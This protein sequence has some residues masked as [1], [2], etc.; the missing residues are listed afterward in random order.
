VLVGTDVS[1]ADEI[2]AE[3]ERRKKRAVALHLPQTI[4]EFFLYKVRNY[5]VWRADPERTEY[6][7]QVVNDLEQQI[8]ETSDVKVYLFSHGGT[9]YRFSWTQKGRDSYFE[10]HSRY[11][12]IAWTGNLTLYVDD[13]QVF[14]MAL[15]GEQDIPGGIDWIPQSVEAFVEG[16]WVEDLRALVPEKVPGGC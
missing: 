14:A 13:E 1:D 9:R 6:V 12:H 7:P 4:S 8:G 16:R 5:P 11:D 2:Y 3:V 15:R 10:E